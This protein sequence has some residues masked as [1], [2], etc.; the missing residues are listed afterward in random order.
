MALNSAIIFKKET[1]V[2]HIES[3]IKAI[4]A[5]TAS[6]DKKANNPAVLELTKLTEIADYFVICSGDSHVHVK[7]IAEHIDDELRKQGIKP[8][9]VEGLSSA[10]W[11]LMDYGDVIVHVFDNETRFYYELEK[12]WL[13]APRIQFEDK[14]FLAR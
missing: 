8:L 10:R 4:A 11:V 1:E 7:A 14:D 12:L 5:A 13:D 9:S 6:A 2:I 3:K